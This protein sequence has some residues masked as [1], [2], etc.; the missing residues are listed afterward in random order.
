M[1]LCYEYVLKC[2]TL[3]RIDDSMQPGQ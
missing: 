1:I 3:M 2:K